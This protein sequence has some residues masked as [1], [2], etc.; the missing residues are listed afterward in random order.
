LDFSIFKNFVDSAT[1]IK[2]MEL[3]GE[4]EPLLHPQFFEMIAYARKRFPS[5]EIS[6]IT[7]GSLFTETII[8]NILSANIHTI[9]ISI[10][11]ADEAEFQYIRGGKLSRVVRGIKELIK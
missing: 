4:G 2:H 6:F 5:L 8:K 1:H 3:Q 10:E 11:S 9:L 7:N